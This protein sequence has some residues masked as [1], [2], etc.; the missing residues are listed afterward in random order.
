[1]YWL[2][3]LETGESKIEW[4]TPSGGLIAK[5]SY[6]WKAKRELKEGWMLPLTLNPLHSS[7]SNPFMRIVL[8]WPNHLHRD[9][10]PSIVALGLSFQCMFFREH[11]ETRA[12][13]QGQVNKGG[14]QI[15][16][17]YKI[18]SKP[19]LG[20]MLL[21]SQNPYFFTTSFWGQGLTM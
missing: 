20:Q 13:F 7:I 10:L 2:T 12:L 14:Y 1:M 6:G 5:S 17:K 19:D 8:F 16:N 21:P 9:C 15:W 4:V 3:V 11:N 18:R